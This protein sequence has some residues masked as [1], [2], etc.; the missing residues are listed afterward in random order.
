LKGSDLDELLK[1]NAAG[2]PIACALHQRSDT[3]NKQGQRARR[4]TIYATF[5]MSI[6]HAAQV[7]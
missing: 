1:Q 2:T 7:T 4:K 6:Y 5:E 3:H